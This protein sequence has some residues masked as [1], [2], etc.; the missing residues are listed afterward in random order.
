MD[1]CFRVE[2]KSKRHCKMSSTNNNMSKP[3]RNPEKK[4]EQIK[5]L[6]HLA[7]FIAYPIIMFLS[8]QNIKF[9]NMPLFLVVFV[10][11][12]TKYHIC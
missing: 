5:L 12:H 2:E 4:N 3:N 9:V 10:V 7:D 1:G 8:L 11:T 6:E